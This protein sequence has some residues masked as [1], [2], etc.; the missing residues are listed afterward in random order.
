[1]PTLSAPILGINATTGEYARP[2]AE[3]SGLS[4]QGTLHRAL[5]RLIKF[6]GASRRR[7]LTFC[8]NFAVCSFSAKT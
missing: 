6:Q 8:N 4:G 2:V 1:M 5:R 7:S 3:H